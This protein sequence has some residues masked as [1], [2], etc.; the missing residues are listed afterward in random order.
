MG[1]VSSKLFRKD[2]S[3]ENLVQK[4]DNISN[5]VVSLTSSTYGV[6]RLDKENQQQQQQG[7]HLHLQQQLQSIK[8]C[9]IDLKK[10]SP[11]RQEPEVINA[12]EIMQG[13]EEEVP[14][15]NLIP[16][17]KSP[18][19]RLLL[20]GFGDLD[21]RSPL[22]FLNQMASPRKLKKFGGKENATPK[23]VFKACNMQGS[24]QKA[25]PMLR[26]PRKDS[27]ND[28]K[29]E[30]L[31]IDSGVVLSRRRSLGPLFDPELVASFEKELSEEKEQ[32][33]KMVS[34]TPTAV[35]KRNSQDSVSI[36]ENFEEK[37]PPGGENAVVLYTTTLRGIRK[38]FEDCNTAR[39]VIESH[40]VQM[41]E[42]DVSMHSGFKDEL[43]GLMGT[44]EVKVPLVFVKGR[45]IGGAD[46]IVKLEEDGKLGTLFSGI[47]KAVAICNGCA[48]V[49][50]VLCID[51]NGSCKVLDEK[52][53]K[54][55]KCKECNENGL[56]QCPF[57]S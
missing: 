55:V 30:S 54:T 43:R 16:D 53:K 15:S 38:T 28:A 9:G 4:A 24:S 12:W 29:C 31:R 49:R 19:S 37:C 6:L 56:I 36:L 51:C 32:I 25:S 5:H 27:P 35:K 21:A 23:S 20:R 11:P 48:G 46:E 18:K 7:Q 52:G 57:C 22:K 3:Q 8:K 10:P 50:F 44:K 17:K 2:L 14:L 1:C 41:F 26:V 42:R 40:Q 39:S 34:G 47:P 13:L 45:L 33:K